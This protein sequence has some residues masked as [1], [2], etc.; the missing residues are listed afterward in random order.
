MIEITKKIKHFIKYIFQRKKL[1]WREALFY[2]FQISWVSELI[3]DCLTDICCCIRAVA[4][5]DLAEVN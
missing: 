1:V 3:E 2:I 4:Y 5:V